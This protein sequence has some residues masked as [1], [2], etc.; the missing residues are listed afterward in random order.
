[1]SNLEAYKKAL[2]DAIELIEDART[3]K[4]YIA[5]NHSNA[6]AVQPAAIVY[7]VSVEEVQKCVELANE[8]EIPL[9][10]RSSA[11]TET[12][13]GTSLPSVE[14]SVILNLSKMNKVINIDPLNNMAVIEA[15]VTYEQLNK[16]LKKYGL[17]MEHPLSPRAEKSVIASLLDR[18]PVMT[19]KHI[20]DI[21]DPLCAQK[22]VF[23][24]GRLFGSGSA[25]GP[26]TLEEMLEA[27]CAMN[28]AQGP[29]WL[30]L[31]RVITGAQGTLAAVCWASV[32]VRMIGSVHQMTYVQS[33]DIDRLGE[34]ASN[35]I[36]RRLGEEAVLLNR[37]GMERVF[38]ISKE[39]A[40]KMPK[41]T[42]VSSARGFRYF[43]EDYLNNQVA[44]MA[45]IAGEFGLELKTE[46]AGLDNDAAWK[47][48]NGSSK[49]N[50]YWK[51]DGKKN[52]C[53]V[54]CLNTIDV[55]G[56]FTLLAEKAA[57]TAGADP[58]ELIVYAQPS[59]MARNCHIEFVINIDGDTRQLEDYIGTVLLDNN[60]FFSRPYGT[61][62]E[63]VYEKHTQQR[64]FMPFIKL[65][66]DEKCI[67]NKGKL[68]AG[69]QGGEL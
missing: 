56:K 65:M 26:G 48:L 10:V 60:A 36:R 42:Y 58:E 69:Y 64:H 41:W 57:E 49:K 50:Q 20:W 14:G 40:A 55:I 7:P 63:K 38:G 3:L 37:K 35:V 34:Y 61:I 51:L 12:F 30:D 66:L 19:A 13:S 67:L 2:G 22:M 32:K 21:P 28:Q 23:G 46:L 62:A 68:A 1:M 54:F 33:D 11:G 5:K 59:Q 24:N 52:I 27:G 29:V 18:D 53:D 15:G 4:S 16:E 47:V 45:D 44:D 43:A 17:Y 31:G 8:Y 39:E 6:Q 9:T 25:A